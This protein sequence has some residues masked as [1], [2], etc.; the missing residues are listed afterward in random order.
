VYILLLY[1]E[2]S[3]IHQRIKNNFTNATKNKNKNEKPIK[4]G[5]IL[6]GILNISE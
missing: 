2:C 4:D 5:L 3:A 1:F 6:A